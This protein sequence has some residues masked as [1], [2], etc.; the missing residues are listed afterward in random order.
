[1]KTLSKSPDRQIQTS[2]LTWHCL[3]CGFLAIAGAAAAD[4]VVT[5]SNDE[6]NG[7]LDPAM[8]SGTSLREA[9]LHAPAGS[10]IVFA[11]ALHGFVFALNDG[12]MVISRNLTIDGSTLSIG[13]EVNAQEMSRVF[14]VQAGKTVSMIRLRIV[15]GKVTG[16]GGGI[17]NAGNLT[18]RDCELTSNQATGGGGAI[19]NSGTLSLNACTLAGN[20]AGVGGGGIEHASGVLSLTNCTMTGNSA[21]WGGAIDG[22]GTS[23]IRLYSCTLSGNHASDKGGGIEET[24]GT[25]LLENSIV[26]GNTATNSGPDLKA[27]SINTQLGVNLISSTNGLGGSYSGIVGT[28]DL[29]P[30]NDYGGPTRTL[31]PL[32][33]SPAR[34]AGGATA[35]TVDQRGLPR[36]VGAAVDIGAVEVQPPLVVTT[37][38]DFGPGSLR[39][40]VGI[41]P[42]GSTITFDPSLDGASIDVYPTMTGDGGPE[43]SNPIILDKCLIIDASERED[44]EVVGR[45]LPAYHT[46]TELLQL[47][48]ETSVA[49]YNLR[50]TGAGGISGTDGP[51]AAIHNEGDLLLDHCEFSDNHSSSDGG[52]ITNG[53][54]ANLIMTRCQLSRNLARGGSGGAILNASGGFLK[55]TECVVVDNGAFSEGGGIFNAAGALLEV[56][57]CEIVGNCSGDGGGVF[58]RGN[59]VFTRTSLVDNCAGEEGGFGGGIY[60]NGDL[61]LFDSVVRS[62]GAFGGGGIES[63]GTLLMK[64][65][66]VEDNETYVEGDGGGLYVS[67]AGGTIT[68]CTFA[69][70]YCQYSGAGIFHRA[71]NLV[72]VNTTLAG[73]RADWEFGGGIF[74]QSVLRVESCTI[75]DNDANYEAGGIYLDSMGQLS[76][77]NSVV[78]RNLTTDAVAPDIRGTIH[79]QGGV[80][81]VSSGDGI[82]NPFT[83]IVADPLLGPLADNGG[84]TL[85]MLPLPGSPAID[86]GG[87]TDL[88]VDQRGFPRVRG[89]RVDIGSVETEPVVADWIVNTAADE[90]DGA[91]VGHVSL[92]EAIA[93]A[94]PGANIYFAP[95][96][97]A[98]AILLTSGTLLIDK[99]LTIDASSLLAGVSVSGNK[100]FRVFDIA[101]GSKVSMHNISIASGRVAASGGGIRN[102]GDL[103]MAAC[104]VEACSAGDDGGGIFN[105]GTLALNSS[106]LEGNIAGDS[107]GA[108][109]SHGPVLLRS[110]VVSSNNADNG[111]GIHNDGAVITIEDSTLG[112]N[113]A[114]DTPGGGAIDNDGGEVS[115]TRSTLSGN[116]SASGGGAIENDGTLTILAC[117]LSGNTA[118]V[119]GGAI[120]HAAGVLDLTSNTLAGNSAKYGGAIDGDGT[121]TIRLNCCTVANNH[122]SDK[123]GGIEETT[124]TLVLE[125]SIVGANSA[126]NSGPDLK[127][128]SINSELGVNLVSSTNGL[129]GSFYG[130]VG[131]PDLLPLADNGGPSA[132]MLPRISSPVI[133]AAGPTPLL[134]D[135]R[136]LPRTA[137]ARMDAGAVELEVSSVVATTADSGPGSLRYAVRWLPPGSMVTF[138][139]SLDG[140]TTEFA[141]RILLEKDV[142]IDA[143]DR[144]GL[145]VSGGDSAAFFEVESTAT[146][147]IAG[148]VFRD[149]YG[150]S[151]SPVESEGKLTVEDCLFTSGFGGQGGAIYSSGVLVMTGCSLLEN[152]AYYDGGAIYSTGSATLSECIIAGNTVS[153]EFGFHGAGGGIFSS[154]SLS[155]L[156]SE[157]RDNRTT[158][159]GSGI[160][161]EGPLKM[162]RCTVS[163]NEHQGGTVGE[164]F[165]VGGGVYSAGAGSSITACN[166]SENSAAQGAGVY[167]F[168]GD[169]T[170]TNSTVGGNEAGEGGGI[171]IRADLRVE[172]CTISGND[173]WEGGGIYVESAGGGSDGHLTLG[174]SIIAANDADEAGP[175]VRG[176]IDAEF[177]VNLLG[178]TDGVTTP[179]AGIV[180][181]PLLSPLGNYGGP[182]MTMLP[183]PGSPAIDAGGATTQTLDQRGFNR[184]VGAKVDIGSVETGN[185]IPP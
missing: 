20:T 2:R 36:V 41:A 122:A 1:M 73:N 160:A 171:F 93:A 161:S 164:P 35:L 74:S 138:A 27:S 87:S 114:D 168:A 30:L 173:A 78:A 44:L 89:P 103:T 148:L 179:F 59:A 120:E 52:A 181:D 17:R 34:N 109:A 143:T 127:V 9:V 163:G 90:N 121:S 48:H 130:I 16:D 61:R 135:Q 58:S 151:G 118:A 96:V 178:S 28:A 43:V 112:N 91:G 104:E 5:T 129:G 136:G 22:D 155:V 64:R 31:L 174:N 131:A 69:G 51:G 77:V 147:K 57:D 79:T 86:A 56:T 165:L 39:H 19:E 162:L 125:N 152:A 115:I 110:C 33:G 133:D 72:L 185:V 3:I 128:S 24:T 82:D 180:A 170:I 54:T 32:P 42:S 150:S 46:P 105:T 142:V 108:I 6:N 167:L 106:R 49:I 15:G 166:I 140:S 132:T 75:V 81:L 153:E 88:T 26:A 67:G 100:R 55:M 62:N 111:G 66:S 139:P 156:D 60:S 99:D 154:G 134:T 65:C 183:L 53:G 107:G 158:F 101:A 98:Q 113:S 83:G 92:R 11:P 23:T 10:T 141:R 38:L 80:N 18:L 37:D 25:L 21:Q 40:T 149:G 68:G 47:P 169:L 176:P 145:V 14:E 119:G 13:V 4:V 71:G 124:G 182:T 84:P 63:A 29:M 95:S 123:G 97:N 146:V 45:V 7:S 94:A 144:A 8:G 117:T 137:G 50:F 12:Q 172:S 177:G 184:V 159:V 175:D 157:V 102:A 76:L 70:N 126:T 85:T 116:R